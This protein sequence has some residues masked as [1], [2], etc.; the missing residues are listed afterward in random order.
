M[1]VT[2]NFYINDS[3]TNVVN[4]NLTNGKTINATLKTSTNVENPVFVLSRSAYDT[5]YNYLYCEEL[6]RYYFVDSPV[7]LQGGLIELSCKVDVLETYA[8]EIKNLTCTVARNEKHK[9]GYLPDGKY[10]S[11]A[12]EQ[13]VTKKFPNPINND[14]VILMTMG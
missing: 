6:G 10:K 4:K 14:C 2:L 8:S 12:Y 7:I 9:N 1:N 11:V 3:D 13:I 5:Y